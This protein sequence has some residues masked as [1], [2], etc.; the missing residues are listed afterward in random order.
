MWSTDMKISRGYSL[1]KVSLIFPKNNFLS[2]PIYTLCFIRFFIYFIGKAA[3]LK[4]CC[5]SL[6]RLVI[7]FHEPMLSLR[8]FRLVVGSNMGGYVSKNVFSGG[9]LNLEAPAFFFCFF[10]NGC[11]YLMNLS[12]KKSR[13]LMYFYWYYSVSII[14]M[15]CLSRGIPLKSTISS[16]FSFL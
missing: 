2:G 1:L 3:S 5:E 14:K 10:G 4:R 12:S 13:R 7:G 11:G 8:G 16:L 6:E 15:R 9:R